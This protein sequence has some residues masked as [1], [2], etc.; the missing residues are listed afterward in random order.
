MKLSNCTNQEAISACIKQTNEVK[1]ILAE[2]KVSVVQLVELMVS[3]TEMK[4]SKG[5]LNM[6]SRH[7]GR[8]KVTLK[9]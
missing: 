7:Y 4:Y 8:S 2:N 3:E 1:Q 6:I 9:F 5:I